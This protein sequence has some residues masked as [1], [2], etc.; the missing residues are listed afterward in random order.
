MRFL[1]ATSRFE[2]VCIVGFNETRGADL[3][4]T[5]LI[6]HKGHLLDTTANVPRIRRS[7]SRDESSRS[8]RTKV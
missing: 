4:N 5:A 7:I 3:Y 2:A 6:A 8:S 1:D